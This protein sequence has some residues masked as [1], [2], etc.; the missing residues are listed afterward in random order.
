L[1]KTIHEGRGR[2]GDGV[3]TILKREDGKVDCL[4]ARHLSMVKDRV[5]MFIAM[6]RGVYCGASKTNSKSQLNTKCWCNLFCHINCP[7][8]WSAVPR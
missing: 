6:R 7:E 2:S 4:C 8:S 5:A 3:M 1:D